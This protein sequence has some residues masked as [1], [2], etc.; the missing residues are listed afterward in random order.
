M[1]Y[2]PQVTGCEKSMRLAATAI[3]TSFDTPDAN[4]PVL[5]MQNSNQL[6]LFCDLTLATATSAE[7]KV[8][9]AN[10]KDDATPP[11]FGSAL[12]FDLPYTTAGTITAGLATVPAGSLAYSMSAT[13]K[14]AI[15][16]PC[17]FKYVR[18]VAKTTVGPGA[19]T[20]AITASQ[21]LA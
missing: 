3:T 14:I 7:I 9:V 1:S 19:T 5:R 21:G 12:W 8:Q 11:A 18:V 15:T 20:L 6:V 16:Y 4:T 13:G 17:C 2:N 10:P